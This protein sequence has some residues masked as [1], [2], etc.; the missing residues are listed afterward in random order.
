LAIDLFVRY[1]P[2]NE[3]A[4]ILLKW[5][6]KMKSVFDLPFH[7]EPPSLSFCPRSRCFGKLGHDGVEFT[8]AYAIALPQGLKASDVCVKVNICSTFRLNL[9]LETV[10]YFFPAAFSGQRPVPPQ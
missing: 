7:P 6:L 5:R 4:S 2:Y 9:N 10:N 3:K 1:P 8:I